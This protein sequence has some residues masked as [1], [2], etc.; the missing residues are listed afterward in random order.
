MK[1]RSVKLP[2][3]APGKLYLHSMPGRREP[4]ADV[5]AAVARLDVDAIVC[6]APL[7]EVRKK[8]PAYA[9]AIESGQLPCRIRWLPVEDYQGPEDDEAFHR[10]AVDVANSLRQGEV[11]LVHCGAGIGRTGMF[12]VAVLMSLGLSNEE[13]RLVAGAAGSAP[14][15]AS[16]NEALRR[17]ATLLDV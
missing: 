5:W 4:L 17:F 3:C 13:A 10:F 11:V 14:E 9:K 2:V 6:L 16:Q 8:S 1:F 12:T 7:D 15:R